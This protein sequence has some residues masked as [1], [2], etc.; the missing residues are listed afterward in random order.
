MSWVMT[1][2]PA[3]LSWMQETLG[4]GATLLERTPKRSEIVISM[5][6]IVFWAASGV[7]GTEAEPILS[8][9]L[10]RQSTRLWRDNCL[11]I[12]RLLPLLVLF[13]DEVLLLTS[14][15]LLSFLLVPQDRSRPLPWSGNDS[16]FLL[17]RRK[18]KA[19]PRATPRRFGAF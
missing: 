7:P 10:F 13:D 14:L 17:F 16:N 4:V 8:L 15:L 1:A 6:F 2:S 18:E 5:L 11:E 12:G 3:K 9:L 19:F